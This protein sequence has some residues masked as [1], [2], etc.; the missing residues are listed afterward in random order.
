MSAND[1]IQRLVEE[2]L[3]VLEFMMESSKSLWKKFWKG[4]NDRRSNPGMINR[5]MAKR[6]RE[7]EKQRKNIIKSPPTITKNISFVK[8]EKLPIEAIERVLAHL[9]LLSLVRACCVCRQWRALIAN[10]RFLVARAKIPT[11]ANPSYFPMVGLT[12]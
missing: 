10:P 7:S 3:R 1:N 11:V 5:W 4:S 12:I 8:K 9:P 2:V 6:N